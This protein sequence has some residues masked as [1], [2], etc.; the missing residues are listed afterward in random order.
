MNFIDKLLLRRQRLEGK[1][2]AGAR[3]SKIWGGD[4]KIR[5]VVSEMWGGVSKMC[6]KSQKDTSARVLSGKWMAC[7]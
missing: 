2:G 5:G 7:L 3:V 6:H 1:S 4:S